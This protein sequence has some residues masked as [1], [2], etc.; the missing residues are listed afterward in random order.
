[1]ENYNFKRILHEIV[2]C[3]D[4]MLSEVMKSKHLIKCLSDCYAAEAVGQSAQAPAGRGSQEAHGIR[5]TSGQ[6][7]TRLYPSMFSDL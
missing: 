7:I 5:T 2:M 6:V 1:M 3:S 4:K